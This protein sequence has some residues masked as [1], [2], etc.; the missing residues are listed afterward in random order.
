M[1]VERADVLLLAYRD[2]LSRRWPDRLVAAQDFSEHHLAV[3]RRAGER[4]KEVAVEAADFL[5][6]HALAERNLR[7]L[8]RRRDHDVEAGYLGAAFECRR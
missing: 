1:N 6:E 7:L 5:T 2:A 8:D 4:S 3:H